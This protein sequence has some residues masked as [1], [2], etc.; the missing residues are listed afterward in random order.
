[1]YFIL[2][3]LGLTLISVLG[4]VIIIWRKVPYLKKLNVDETALG[5]ENRDFTLQDFFL[6]FIPEFKGESV[7]TRAKEYK[8]LWLSELEKFIRKLRLLSLKVDRISES[9]IKRIRRVNKAKIAP[10]GEHAATPEP[11]IEAKAEPTPVADHKSP[12]RS[13]EIL[14]QEEH[15]LIIE[16]AKDPRNY[17]L[18]KVLGNLY[19]EMKNYSDAKDSFEAALELNPEDPELKEKLSSVL[20]NLNQAA[21]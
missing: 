14:K 11:V 5:Q 21:S 4:I 18:Y 12:V 16:I 8:N 9:L 7:N 17:R 1:M 2:I 15:R 13:L 3:P 20:Q 6:D 10:V 19:V